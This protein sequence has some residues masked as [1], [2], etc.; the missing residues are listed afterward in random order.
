MS[1]TENAKKYLI[2]I[3]H[4]VI[5]VAAAKTRTVE[6]IREAVQAGIKYIGENYIQEAESVIPQIQ[7]DVKWHFIGKLQRNKVKK[8]VQL[9][10]IIETVDSC[11]LAKEI[12]KRAEQFNK[13]IEV[14]I[15]INIGEEPNKSGVYP[16]DAA[17]LVQCIQEMPFLKLT[18]FM[19]MGPVVDD[20]EALRP[21]FRKAAALF[22]QYKNDTVKYLSMGMT[23]SYKVAIDEGSNII[24]IGTGLF[25]PR[26][27]QK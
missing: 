14:F 18:G 2:N 27:Y 26:N 4:N 25:G 21:Y 13:T 11:K 10:D 12:N 3:P 8:A 16:A 7:D 19:T 15:E 5:L 1:I 6:E 9:F 17:E 23:D 24:R 22:S 20:P